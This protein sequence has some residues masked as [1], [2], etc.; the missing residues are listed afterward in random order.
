[1]MN[2]IF[3]PSLGSDALLWAAVACI[4]VAIFLLGVG[5][6]LRLGRRVWHVL[7]EVPGAFRS[8]QLAPM[9]P[10]ER[11]LYESLE[12]RDAH[13]SDLAR[14]LQRRFQAYADLPTV[15]VYPLLRKLERR[16]LVRS[17]RRLSSLDKRWYF[18]RELRKRRWEDAGQGDG[19]LR[20]DE[21]L[22]PFA[23]AAELWKHQ[24]DAG[25]SPLAA[26]EEGQGA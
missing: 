4:L 23:Y 14:Q 8:G 25:H 2:P 7:Q 9:G 13:G 22:H 15:S 24:H 12:G 18:T 17:Y 20:C 1:M 3:F 11:A 5:L 21:C 6:L 19:V 16:N 26:N 10:I